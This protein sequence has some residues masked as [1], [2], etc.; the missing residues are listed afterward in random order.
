[1][2]QRQLPEPDL[3][4]ETPVI[5]SQDLEHQPNPDTRVNTR[6]VVIEPPKEPLP[7]IE[8]ETLEDEDEMARDAVAE[9]EKQYQKLP[10]G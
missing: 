1:M 7:R 3:K 5:Q 9:F 6:G 2:P 4:I 8:I 10:P